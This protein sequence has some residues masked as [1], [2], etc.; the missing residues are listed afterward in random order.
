MQTYVL[1]F[2]FTAD[3]RVVL[4]LKN[5][6]KWQEGFLNGVGGKIEPD[7]TPL[8]AMV[9]EFREET[10]MVVKKWSK[11][12]TLTGE[13]YKV[14]VFKAYHHDKDPPIRSMTDEQV[15]AYPTDDIPTLHVIPNLRWM[16]PLMTHPQPYAH[17][18]VKD[19]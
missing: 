18:I 5:R 8:Q 16:I 12:L 15:W 4:I 7:E 10:G 17:F 9:R 3:N 1:G 14:Q 19:A 11:V 2:L 13:G 6:P